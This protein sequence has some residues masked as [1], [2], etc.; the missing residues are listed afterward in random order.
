MTNQWVKLVLVAVLCSFCWLLAGCSQQAPLVDTAFS[1]AYTNKPRKLYKDM[2]IIQQ[3]PNWDLLQNATH[4]FYLIMPAPPGGSRYIYDDNGETMDIP[5][6]SEYWH[7]RRIWEAWQE[8]FRSSRYRIV[9]L[10]RAGTWFQIMTISPDT[11]G[12]AFRVAVRIDSGPY[13]GKQVIYDEQYVD[14]LVPS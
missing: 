2:F 14:E 10:I 8:R 6:V 3:L 5:T 13:R 11:T 1:Q 12:R 9:G 4:H 7:N